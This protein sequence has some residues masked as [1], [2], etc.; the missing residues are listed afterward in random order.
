MITLSLAP[1][2]LGEVALIVADNGCGIAPGDVGRVFDRLFS[3]K[4]GGSGLGLSL[5]K[6]IVSNHGGTIGIDSRPG[7]GTRVIMRFPRAEM[8]HGGWG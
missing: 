5:C 3:T 8:R 2:D 4:P 7:Q 1:A 6:R